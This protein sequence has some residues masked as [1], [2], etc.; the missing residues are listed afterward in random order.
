MSVAKK[1]VAVVAGI[2][3]AGVVVVAVLAVH[4]R[5]FGGWP[6][7]ADWINALAALVAA[8]AL[9]LSVRRR[10]PG[11]MTIALATATAVLSLAVYVALGDVQFPY[12]RW[13]QFHYY[14]GA[15]YLPEIGY[16]RIYQCTAVAEAE[17]FGPAAVVLRSIRDLRTEAIVPAATALADPASCKR[18]FSPARW[19][20]FVDDVA[21]FR[22]DAPARSYWRNMQADHGFNGAPAWSIAGR[23]L[24]SLG[25]ASAR[26]QTG[27]ALIDPVL[28]A[29]AF[30]LIGWAFGV[31]VVWVALVV[32]GCQFPAKGAW[33]VGG[34]LRQDWFLAL[35]ASVCLA[36][37]ERW[38]AAGLALATSAMIRLFPAV[39]LGVPMLVAAR[40][41]VASRT[42]ARS[43]R[44][45]ALG[46]A[47]G[48]VAWFVTA[49]ADFGIPTWL[50]FRDHIVMHNAEP[51]AN[52]IGLRGLLSQTM[53]GRLAKTQQDSATDPYHLWVV[54]REEAFA[55]RRPIY[56]ALVAGV[57]A[58]AAIAAGRIRE[59][60][61]ALA[62]STVLVVTLLDIAS[63]Y[64]AMFVL[65]PLLAA[66]DRRHEW[67]AL[68]AIVV[69][70]VV[71][72]T[73]LVADSADL[74]YAAQS[75]V[76]LA[77]AAASLASLGPTPRS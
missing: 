33:T 30:A 76:F 69:S 9:A 68:G 21:W 40:R 28:L 25:P 74:R 56:L 36:R 64:C 38:T 49:T 10:R 55:A 60:W 61:V 7:G 34:F 5:W 53:E 2:G 4:Y 6:V 14:I 1:A 51:L 20:A 72:A 23:A 43:D 29:I 58:M 18:H 37:R 75:G 26:L 22:N 16:T 54:R 57:F 50:D 41:W 27:L 63:Y 42:I 62:A 66:V 70:R 71:N 19:A 3:L 67:L 77:W 52:H 32:W 47:L 24:A 31:R 46:L 15:K 45:F 44:R 13:D 35:V 11:P 39:L 8:A 48:A 65:L 12:H 17:R 73:P 59:L